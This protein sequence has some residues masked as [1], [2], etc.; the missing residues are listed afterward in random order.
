MKKTGL[1]N[2]IGVFFVATL[3]AA[4]LCA[5]QSAAGS[6]LQRAFFTRLLLDDDLEKSRLAARSIARVPPG[7]D[8][9]ALSDLVAEHLLYLVHSN[10]GDD[11]V[12]IDS[13][14]WHVVVLTGTSTGRYREILDKVRQRYTQKKVSERID[15][16][17]GAANA[18]TG[19]LYAGQGLNIAALRAGAD[20]ALAAS[21]TRDRSQFVKLHPGTSLAEVL[22]SVGTPDDVTTTT[23]R[24]ARYGR[25][26]ML[27]MH[28]AG[29]GL[30]FFRRGKRE[31]DQWVASEFVDEFFD[32]TTVYKGTQFGA[33]QALAS[34]RGLPFRE[35]FRYERKRIQNDPDMMDV[36]EKRALQFTQPADGFE[37]SGMI[38]CVR[39]IANS[40]NPGNRESLH[41][42]AVGPAP[43][44]VMAEATKY[45]HKLEQGILEHESDETG[46]VESDD[47]ELKPKN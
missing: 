39:L 20:A 16:A 31:E 19:S 30:V 34:L 33:A 5:A 24:V 32:V 37:L 15:L 29:S 2:F 40:K 8:T 23:V 3:L 14:A 42:I 45:A 38:A 9:E 1:G 11:P 35:Y 17:L 13:I 28:Y 44:R 4:P 43:K 18:S 10:P 21:R 25:S 47:D 26:Q 27:T 7:P 22:Q 36:F 12:L 41:R 46:P 6:A